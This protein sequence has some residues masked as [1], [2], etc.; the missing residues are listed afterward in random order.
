MDNP[1]ER[2]QETA[3]AQT[4]QAAYEEGQLE[5]RW[6]LNLDMDRQMSAQALID[7]GFQGQLRVDDGYTFTW[8][9][10]DGAEAASGHQPTLEAAFDQASQGVQG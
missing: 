8:L 7:R 5:E 6:M 1:E 9:D 10:A 2:L 3:E 4:L